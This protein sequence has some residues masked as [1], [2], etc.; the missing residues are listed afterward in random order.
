MLADETLTHKNLVSFL[1]DDIEELLVKGYWWEKR[2]S[3]AFSAFDISVLLLTVDRE[4]WHEA[5]STD[6]T[7]DC[8]IT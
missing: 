8:I 4:L 2:E 3:L 1:S 5:L 7:L 6:W